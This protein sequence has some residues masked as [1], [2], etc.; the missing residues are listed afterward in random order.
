MTDINHLTGKTEKQFFFEVHLNWLE[1]NRG[2]LYARDVNENLHV[3]TPTVFGGHG[4]EWSPEHLFL[5]SIS[6]CFMST[7][8]A[9]AKKMDVDISHFE[10]S[11]IGQI[12]TAEGKYKFT[13][14]NLYPRV[15]IADELFFE[16]ANRVLEK[17]QKYCLVSNSVN[18]AIIYHSEI[19][20]DKHPRPQNE[21]AD[22][23]KRKT[24]EPVGNTY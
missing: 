3:A 24:N 6:S 1:Q 10:C 12:E 19:L 2:I 18:A 14:I 5:S 15:F 8:L 11:A 16:K 17:T 22:A 7:Y 21:R 13:H 9:L 23:I 4:K 20:V